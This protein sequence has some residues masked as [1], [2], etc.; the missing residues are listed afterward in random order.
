MEIT[1]APSGATAASATKG[2][3]IANYALQYLGYKYVYGSESPSK[4]FDCSGLVYYTFGQFGYKLQRS[5]SQQYKNNGTT[6]AKSDL[7]PGDLV[8][9]SSNGST[10]THVG[11]YIGDNEFVHASTSDTGVII[12]NL[13]SAYYTKVW[14]GAK[15]I[16][17]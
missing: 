15:R 8:F 7:K 17:D 3:K 13:T 12:S 9:F 16:V 1:G 4:G 6:I 2:Q 5:A 14:F 10:V 11:I